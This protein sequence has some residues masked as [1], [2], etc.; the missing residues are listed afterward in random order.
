MTERILVPLDGSTVAEGALAGAT[1]LAKHWD[2]DVVLVR[3]APPLE[4][5]TPKTAQPQVSSPEVQA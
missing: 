1:L 3:V 2:A 5:E 4:A